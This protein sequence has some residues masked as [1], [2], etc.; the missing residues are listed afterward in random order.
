MS[1][2]KERQRN[3]VRV[4]VFVTIALILSMAVIMALTDFVGGL[5]RDDTSYTVSFHVAS[6]VSSLQP[7]A[8]VRVGGLVMG[9]VVDV[10]PDLDSEPFDTIHVDI[11]LDSSVTLY[12]NAMIL[13]ST[14]LLGS[15]AWLD[16]PSV[17]DPR[18]GK[19][20]SAGATLQAIDSVGL[21]TKLLGPINASKAA[22]IVDDLQATIASTKA[23]AADIETNAGPVMDDLQAI[24]DKTR[25]LV[26]QVSDEDMPRWSSQVD[27]LFDWAND[28]T[29]TINETLEDGRQFMTSA[30]GIAED[31]RED[32]GR[33]VDNAEA[34]SVRLNDEIVDKA[35][36]LLD[37][38]RQGLD[39]AIAVLDNIKADYEIW[40]VSIGES[41]AN[42]N[43]ASQQLNLAMIEIRRSPWKVL[44]RPTE[45]ELEHEL[46]YEATRSF[47]VAAADMKAASKS[48]SRILEKYGDQ[49]AGDENLAQR[50]TRALI[51]PLERY[52]KAQQQLFDVLVMETK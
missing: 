5:G 7:G 36:A 14:A 37:Q 18:T 30:R 16:C 1:S 41:L 42:A 10:R 47:A 35:S 2:V 40:T 50:I 15:E 9:Q 8:E 11:N 26:E 19:P 3:N 23:V 33:I 17:G 13:L 27:G 32:I 44:Y 34:F 43:L 46:L 28:A 49:I 52:E 38:G 4:G 22:T 39:D 45:K 31:N 24:A 51:D 12:D 29:G 6:G 20:L 21:L 25:E 48:V